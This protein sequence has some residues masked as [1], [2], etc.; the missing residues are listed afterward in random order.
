MAAK[1]SFVAGG[2]LEVQPTAS[3]CCPTPSGGKDLDDQKAYRPG[4][5]REALKNA[6]SEIDIARAQSG[7]I[8]HHGCVQRSRRWRAPPEA[9]TEGLIAKSDVCDTSLDCR[10]RGGMGARSVTRALSRR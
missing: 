7:R 3:R 1:N 2:I 10:Y 8:G 4:Q 5:G 9:L 6:K